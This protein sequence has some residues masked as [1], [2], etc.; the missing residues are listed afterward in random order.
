MSLLLHVLRGTQH[1]EAPHDSR[2]DALIKLAKSAAARSKVAR[3]A[4]NPFNS[5]YWAPPEAQSLA[6][7]R[8]ANNEMWKWIL[9]AAATGVLG[10]G[11]LGALRMMRDDSTYAASPTSQTV[12][13][14][15]AARDDEEELDKLGADTAPAAP[16]APTAP[17]PPPVPPVPPAAAPRGLGIHGALS[18][19]TSG[20]P[21]GKN[22]F[23][24]SDAESKYGVPALWALGIPLSALALGGGWKA[25]DSIMDWRREGELD[26][27]LR[28]A[29]RRY[30]EL[31]QETL[32]KHAAATDETIEE[33][34]EK[35]ADMATQPQE[36]QATRGGEYTGWGL[37][38]LGAYA[39]LS[40][41]ASGKLSYDYFRARDPKGIA[42]EA[43]R[44]R[45]K[46]RFGGT[47]PIYVEPSEVNKL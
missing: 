38:L 18:S 24:G 23:L 35:L 44:R 1:M 28:D 27:E 15:H 30:L 13:V 46:E 31:M 2:Y 42:E 26:D 47:A 43:M 39:L 29:K 32:P 14:P 34:L 41:L 17:T 45:A 11:S 16:A 36:K 7:G 4:W 6:A 22:F 8:A 5:D 37:G 25:M 20:L 21:W 33:E 12:K 19:L 10:R 9:T 40:A 3:S